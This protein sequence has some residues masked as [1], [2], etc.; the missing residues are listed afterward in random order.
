M[1]PKT[2]SKITTNKANAKVYGNNDGKLKTVS[3]KYSSS[4]YE[5]PTGSFNL[6]KPEMIN[7]TPTNNREKCTKYFIFYNVL[8]LD[9][10]SLVISNLISLLPFVPAS[11]HPALR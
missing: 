5:N 2:T 10:S 9:Q 6:I 8:I 7:K 4:L 3:P 1:T 11:V